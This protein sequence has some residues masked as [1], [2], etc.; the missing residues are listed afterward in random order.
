MV[1]LQHDGA[2]RLELGGRYELD[3]QNK[4]NDSC[5]GSQYPHVVGYTINGCE[6]YHK[7]M[8]IRLKFG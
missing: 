3:V 5:K 8:Y 2:G 6:F 7:S 1:V 4:D